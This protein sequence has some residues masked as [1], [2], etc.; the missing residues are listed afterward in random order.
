ML[1]ALAAVGLLATFGASAPARAE[2]RAA[3]AGGFQVAGRITVAQPREAVWAMLLAPDRWWSPQHR[4][5]E[6][7]TLSLDSRPGGCW[8]ETGPD[9]AGAMHLRVGYIN[10][11]GTLQLLGALD[12]LQALGLDG[13]LT[14]TLKPVDGGTDLDWT[15][16]VTGFQPG[17]V[18]AL[19]A[20]VDGVLAEQMG[21]LKAAVEA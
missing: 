16:T 14:V 5:F 3:E 7:S 2:V 13:V 20:P 6:G 9:G 10:P 12:P 15:Y 17:G 19:A 8:C 11:P 18:A 4:W 1:A 21:R